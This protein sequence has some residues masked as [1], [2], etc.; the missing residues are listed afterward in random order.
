MELLCMIGDLMFLTIAHMRNLWS[1]LD[2]LLSRS[3]LLGRSMAGIGF[4]D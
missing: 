1:L 2:P 4:N 3:H